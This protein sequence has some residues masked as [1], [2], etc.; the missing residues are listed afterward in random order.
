MSWYLSQK[1]G[2]FFNLQKFNIVQFDEVL[3][4]RRCLKLLKCDCS[5]KVPDSRH[6]T[7]DV[8]TLRA[9][10]RGPGL[11]GHRRNHKTSDRFSF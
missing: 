1:R 2:G 11:A 4:L 5:R 10:F 3:D 7:D 8:P 6:A 9:L